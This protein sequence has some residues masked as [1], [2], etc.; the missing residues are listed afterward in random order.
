MRIAKEAGPPYF[1]WDTK[2][3]D[4]CFQLTNQVYIGH[5]RWKTVG[6]A[7]R[8]NAHPFMFDD[9]LGAHN[10]TIDYQNKNRL[11]R[12]S[13]FKT[14]SEAIFNN[15]QVHG[16]EDTISR[17]EASEAYAL[18]WYDRRDNSLNF[19]RNKERSLYYVYS[20]T[21]RCI[22]WASEYGILMTALGRQGIKTAEKTYEC[23]PDTWYKW[24][25]PALLMDELPEPQR[26]KLEN[27]K[28]VYP[29]RSGYGSM[30]KN[31]K[32]DISGSFGDYEGWNALTGEWEDFDGAGGSCALPQD[33]KETFLDRVV[34]GV[35]KLV[36]T[37]EY[38]PL[39]DTEKVITKVTETNL[40]EVSRSEATKLPSMSPGDFAKRQK[41][42]RMKANGILPKGP[43]KLPK[44]YQNAEDTI[45]VHQDR[46]DGKFIMFKW[47]PARF[48]WETHKLTKPPMEMPF[49]IQDIN[50]RHTFKHE[51]SGKHKRIYYKGF[52]KSLL[53]QDQ[54]NKTMSSGC[55]NCDRVPEWGNDV[56]FLDDSHAFLCEFCA[57]IPYLADDLRKDL[58]KVG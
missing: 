9:V 6:D 54:F 7:N 30:W 24:P 21:R 33:K 48:E 57:A 23:T 43:E 29:V 46:D 36:E 51:G 31:E 22:F 26:Q 18:T 38:D 12:G 15:I 27:H 42:D 11:E 16:I 25:I 45:R 58:K 5:N 47:D 13:E 49:K 1:L 44:I 53:N 39:T 35:K 3:F 19:I 32:K 55:M 20:D 56:V 34:E 28:V 14:D 50:A 40:K 41:F 10:G 8:R 17:I 37:T 4:K 52:K 2:S